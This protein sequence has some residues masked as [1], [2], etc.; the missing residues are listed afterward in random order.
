MSEIIKNIGI[1]LASQSIFRLF[2]ITAKGFTE[3]RK[4]A[5]AKQDFIGV[6]DTETYLCTRFA[7]GESQMKRVFSV[8]E[9]GNPGANNFL[10][11]VNKV[12]LDIGIIYAGL[13]GKEGASFDL[14]IS[15]TVNISDAR[16]FLTERGLNWAKSA[17]TVDI[18]TLE[19]LLA[20]QCKQQVTDEMRTLTYDALTQ[21]DALPVNWWKNNLP[22]WFTLDWLELMEIKTVQYSSATV[23]KAREIE[24]RRK[25]F[26][27]ELE[28]Q[29]QVHQA[30]VQLEQEK[31][32]FEDEVKDLEANRVISDKL[33]EAELEK[34]K[35][36]L[37]KATI[38]A[39]QEIDLIKSKAQKK[40]AELQAEIDR[41]NS[42]EDLAA[43]RLKQAEESEKR[44]AE[45]L[46]RYDTVKSEIDGSIH[47]LKDAIQE[48]L[49]DAKRVSEYAGGLSSGAMELLGRT[50]G[51]A[52][53]S[54]VLQEKASAVSESI[55]MKK[56]ELRSRDIGTK[57]VDVLSINSTLQFEFLTPKSGYATI[58]NIGTSGKTW[59]QCPNAYVEIENTKVDSGEKYQVPGQMLPS[60]DLA[61][62]G[63]G[64]IE[65][66]PPGWEELVVIVSDKPL[67]TEK[68]LFKS[69]S[70]NPFVE[71]SQDRIDEILELLSSL[72]EKSWNVGILS[73]LVE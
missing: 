34:A 35:L 29:Q 61:R 5:K 51:A 62:N 10:A 36:T 32:A 53:L 8:K 38:E 40:Q 63:L 2:E 24:K 68:D 20:N 11:Q 39:K 47:F 46:E 23:D 42:R 7:D 50:H 41:I 49:A 27:L 17:D 45:M 18:T 72:D 59:L 21:Q 30:E 15:A 69:T 48:G 31:Q 57:K 9:I 4:Q 70:G 1:N 65:V 66:G 16:K 6:P 52:Y 33:R 25:K 54:R 12:P 67:V 44:T 37:E 28:S 22:D 3:R 73:F 19:T 26:D 14:A 56:V 55:M 58:F 71:V 43:E 64:Y 60:D 13:T